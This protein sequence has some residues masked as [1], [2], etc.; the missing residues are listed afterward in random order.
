MTPKIAA[1]E[2]RQHNAI[3]TAR[4]EMTACEMD[5]VFY[6]LSLIKKEDERGIMY[7][8]KVKD[9]MAIT[10]REWHYNQFL[11]A[12]SNLRSREY[13]IE[14]EKRVLQVGLLASAEYIK[15]EGVIELEVSEKVRPY[16]ID[17]KSNF[18]SFRLH[19][20]FSL[21]SKYAKRIYQIASQWK[22]IGESKTFLIHDF[23]V[24]LM[25]KDPKGKEPEQ[26][27]KLSMFKKFVLDTAVNQINA[28]TDLKISYELIKK[29]RSYQSIRFYIN[30]QAP[31]QLPLPFDQ[32]IENARHQHAQQILEDL[33]V[34]DAKLVQQIL[35]DEKLIDSLFK[36]NYDL[37]TGRAK[38]N[39]NPAGL[40]LKVLGL[41]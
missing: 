37:K 27:T 2:I 6:L 23:K 7:Q 3:T 9:M 5:I 34:K 32:P 8:V 40:L 22:D 24:M 14:D 4:Y 17:L 33:G 38:A 21:T 12:T 1:V 36:F 18:T 13:I 31:N 39:K 29:G 16:L 20:A 30:I 28:H 10:G 25:L 19:A 11:E 26:Y 35:T 41:R 15:G